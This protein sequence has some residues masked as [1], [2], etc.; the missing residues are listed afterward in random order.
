M[1]DFLYISAAI[2]LIVFLCLNTV[3]D[4]HIF[5]DIYKFILDAIET[6]VDYIGK[7]NVKRH[8][9]R[10]RREKLVITKETPIVKYNRLVESLI[11]EMNLPLT[12]ESF[13][14]LVFVIF[15]IVVL[16][17]IFFLKSIPLSI[18]FTIAMFIGGFT[19]FVMASKNIKASRIEH[20]MDA[21][22]IICPLARDG[23]FVAIKKTMNNKGVIH[24]SIRPYFQ[25]FL[26]NCEVNGY[27]FKQ[28][29]MLLNSQLGPKFDNFTK[30]AIIFE[31]NERKGMAEVFMDIVDENAVLREINAR[32]DRIFYKMNRDFFIKT[33]LVVLFFLYALTV[34]DF[35]KFMLD[36]Q[37]G[38]MINTLCVSIVC[39]SFARCQALQSNLE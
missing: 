4:L 27:S 17:I 37:V 19:I 28:A 24:E 39:L 23:V 16:L 36:T 9:E 33:L 11:F 22:D 13:N 7:Y 26:D 35:R 1:N 10:M 25:Q 12:L 20:I 6:I 32:K 8:I 21:E 31:T 3:L 5:K 2:G 34:P 29:I 30:K 38:K 14:T 15:A 18:M